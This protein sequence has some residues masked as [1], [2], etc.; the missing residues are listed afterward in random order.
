MRKPLSVLAV[1]VLSLACSSTVQAQEW[2]ARSVRLI[3]PASA[4]S[5]PD[6]A[7]RIMA[8]KLVGAWGKQI[9]VD[10]RPGGNT[11][12]GMEAG[13]RA[14]PDGHNLLFTHAAALTIS[15]YSIKSLP[16]DI[17]K[18]F[19]PI[20]FVGYSPMLITVA[21]D[22]PAK[23]L[24]ELIKLAKAQPGKLSFATPNAK[25]VPHLTGELLNSTAGIRTL[26]VPYRS[27]AQAIQDT[28]GGQV[29]ILIDGATS[30]IG[31]VKTGRIRAIALTAP[32]K[33]EGME[34][35]PLAIDTLPGF[36]ISGWFAVVAPAG[37]PAAIV[38]KVNRD[39]NQ[40]L[41]V[42]DTISRL[43]DIGVVAQGGSPEALAQTMKK[44]RAQYQKVIRDA[45]IQPDV[46]G[47]TQ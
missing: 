47:V 4:G 15:P 20:G 33:L 46:M 12:I 3:V 1:V 27:T 45:N 30:L 31:A 32:Q 37:T 41:Q 8:D 16:Y 36:V 40:Q 17:E 43:R 5:S 9:V 28:M 44:E 7:A 24:D 22:V 29:Q 35:I 26:H 42:P 21:N 39:I 11:V 23:T 10:N 34:N 14:A 19:V 2:P 38:A 6:I 25:N 13:A 18:D